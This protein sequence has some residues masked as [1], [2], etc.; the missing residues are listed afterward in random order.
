MALGADARRVLRE[1]VGQ[2]ARVTAVGVAI[3]VAA[4]LVLSRTL[5]TLLFEVGATDPVTYASIALVLL[6]ATVVASWIP[7]RRATR[8][9]P[10]SALRPE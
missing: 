8:V 9:T 1:V 6:A 4:A 2:A 3:G 10:L 7:A 5:S